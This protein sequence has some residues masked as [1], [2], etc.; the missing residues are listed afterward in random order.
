MAKGIIT[1]FAAV[2][3]CYLMFLYPLG[4]SYQQQ[5]QLAYTLAYS[6]RY[7]ICRCRFVT[8]DLLRRP[9]SMT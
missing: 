8:K 3:A 7:R 6:V 5:E 1:L 4:A 2:I 9:W